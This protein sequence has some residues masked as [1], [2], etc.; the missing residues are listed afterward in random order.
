MSAPTFTPA[1][2]RVGRSGTVVADTPIEG[3]VSGTTD[4]GYYGG[5]LIAETVTPANAKRIVQCVN[6]CAGIPSEVLEARSAGGLPW[7][8][9]DQIDKAAAQDTL[10]AALQY[11]LED[12]LTGVPRA[13]SSCRRVVRDAIAKATG[14]TS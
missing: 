1:P 3:G 6:A 9:A 2:W 5:H 11:V 10:L 4:T 14:S 13:S 8:V 7:S 12:E